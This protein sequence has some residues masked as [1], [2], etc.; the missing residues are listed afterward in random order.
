MAMACSCHG[1]RDGEIVDVIRNG[2][3]SVD[4]V[5][6]VCRAGGSCGSCVGT[7]DLLLTLERA[8]DAEPAA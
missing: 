7:I 2:A 1:I 3:C 6:D 8:L 5:T 4:E